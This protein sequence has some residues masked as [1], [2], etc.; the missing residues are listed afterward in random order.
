ME[1][2]NQ[3]E[4][5]VGRTRP[6]P[7]RNPYFQYLMFLLLLSV[8]F[9]SAPD[10][11]SHPRL[12]NQK[13]MTEM[14]IKATEI[15]ANRELLTP[16]QNSSLSLLEAYV[17]SFAPLSLLPQ[18]GNEIKPSEDSEPSI[19]PPMHMRINLT[20]IFKGSWKKL[21]VVTPISKVPVNKMEFSENV[22]TSSL[23]SDDDDTVNSDAKAE[24]LE[25]YKVS[26][27]FGGFNLGVFSSVEINPKL[28]PSEAEFPLKENAGSIKMQLQ[29]IPTFVNGLHQVGGTFDLMDGETS[30]HLLDILSTGHGFYLSHTADLSLVTNSGFRSKR[31][32]IEFPKPPGMK[33]NFN[34]TLLQSNS[35]NKIAGEE[36][37][38]TAE[39]GNNSD[40]PILEEEGENAQDAV[41]SDPFA[42]M[43]APDSGA[44]DT[45]INSFELDDNG[46]ASHSVGDGSDG[47]PENDD[48]VDDDVK[49]SQL[50]H[51]HMM[52]GSENE[53]PTILTSRARALEVSE[54][55]YNPNPWKKYVSENNCVV[56]DS[57]GIMRKEGT[58]F[59]DEQ[60]RLFRSESS[61]N[62]CFF[63]F[64]LKAVPG[65]KENAL[66]GSSEHNSRVNY[67]YALP[68]NITGYATS[69][70]CG[71]TLHVELHGLHV[72]IER[73][74][75]KAWSFSTIVT[76]ACFSQI[77][78][79]VMQNQYAD[80]QTA[81]AKASLGTVCIFTILDAFMC[82][83]YLTSGVVVESLFNEFITVAFFKLLLFALFEI[84][85]LF[86]VYKAKFPDAFNQGETAR[87]RE[88]ERLY[89]RFYVTLLGLLITG[90]QLRVYMRS[91]LFL[92]SSFYVPQILTNIQRDTGDP[93]HDKFLFGMALTRLFVPLYLYGCPYT[94]VNLLVEESNSPFEYDPLFCNL[95][96]FW[97]GF[98]VGVLYMQK[99]KGPRY[100]IPT[101]FLPAKYD[102]GR[103][104]PALL[105]GTDCVI[106]MLKVVTDVDVGENVHMIT[107]CNHLFHTTC[108]EPW[109]Q[110]KQECPT[111]RARLPP[112]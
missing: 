74:L 6:H 23:D 48:D 51:K 43:T 36:E 97:V 18:T 101:K 81:A 46:D 73:V 88:L 55:K 30:Q 52:T 5:G 41:N 112:V 25:T 63:R 19:S 64:D 14:E 60:A 31:V 10:E 50:V 68:V 65:K 69:I 104:I 80:T 86:T 110:I 3:D 40:T 103:P 35:V 21:D 106:C 59:R 20:G 24:T 26:T 54:S 78:L 108:L 13:I 44:D 62:V 1:V 61:N 93:F 15:K 37:E 84:R 38:A 85:L 75:E 27:S 66:P 8:I 11:S 109:L 45:E 90:W 89:V 72:D 79:L 42:D 91:L 2:Q 32:A 83:A 17:N 47:D 82:L 28:K 98:Q 87:R 7:G 4:N 57:E 77:I 12:R 33:K 107:P 92:A 99:T 16:E 94:F 70:N 49:L 39:E 34:T 102:Y 96:V 58:G 111:C 9:D 53:K 95:L 76:L 100:L 56:W 29:E 67:G 71:V 22:S 105:R